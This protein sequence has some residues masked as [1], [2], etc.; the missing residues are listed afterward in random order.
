[1]P[2]CEIVVTPPTVPV[3]SLPGTVHVHGTGW[4]RADRVQLSVDGAVGANIVAPPSGLIDADLKVPVRPCGPVP[5]VA[6]GVPAP[7]VLGTATLPTEF[8]PGVPF[9]FPV[10]RTSFAVV[11][12]DPTPTPTD[13]P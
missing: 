1:V 13:T 4:P 9:R 10:A 8:A 3:A 11:C 2:R 12:P 6:Q 7:V 5:V